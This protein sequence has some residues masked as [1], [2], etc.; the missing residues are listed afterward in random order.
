MLKSNTKIFNSGEVMKQIDIFGNEVEIE[1]IPVIKKGRKK[2]KTMQEQY[3][4]LKGFQCKRCK[5]CIKYEYHSKVYYKCEL[6]FVSNSQATDI[7]L[8]NTACKKYKE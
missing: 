2:Y 4:E 5:H 8:K 7:R 3:G 6:W 1:E